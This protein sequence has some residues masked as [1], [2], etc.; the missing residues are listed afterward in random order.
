MI[1]TAEIEIKS[2]GFSDIV[3]ISSHVAEAVKKSG[4]KEGVVTV[5]VPG[6]TAGITTIEFEP[7]LVEDMKNALEKL[8]PQG[9]EYAHNK[10]WGDGN[11]FS[12]VRAAF[13]GASK[14]FIVRGKKPV[15]GTWQQIVLI[16]CDNKARRRNIL[17]QVMGE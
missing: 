3:D 17:I 4:V 10:T 11:G 16:D 5:A 6:A 8:F 15:T 14:V 13:L 12:H 1:F 2:S 7:G 9:S